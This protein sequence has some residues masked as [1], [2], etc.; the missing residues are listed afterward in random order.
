MRTQERCR[1]CDC[2]SGPAF[3]TWPPVAVAGAPA[4][5]ARPSANAACRVAAATLDPRPDCCPPPPADGPIPSHPS[6]RSLA[7]SRPRFSLLA[8]P[9]LLTRTPPLSFFSSSAPIHLSPLPPAFSLLLLPPPAAARPH[10]ALSRPRSPSNLLPA[11]RFFASA[12]PILRLICHCVR[13]RQS[14]RSTTTTTATA[15]TATATTT[16]R[17]PSKRDQ[18][19]CPSRRSIHQLACPGSRH[20]SVRVFTFHPIQKISSSPPPTSFFC[21]GSRLPAA[22][23]NPSHARSHQ[24]QTLL[25]AP[26]TL[27]IG[28]FSIHSTRAHIHTHTHCLTRLIATIL[29]PLI[30][31]PC[32]FFDSASFLVCPARPHTL[33]CT[34]GLSSQLFLDHHPPRQ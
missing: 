33:R 28:R 2:A 6:P 31:S 19:A 10:R 1:P 25:I 32:V 16:A 12:Y 23:R 4:T 8:P 30:A 18:P 24:P 7:P 15:T 5:P 14:R 27:P 34:L 13:A 11:L 3:Q 9:L 20:G 22:T 29:N 26:T 21:A 17:Y